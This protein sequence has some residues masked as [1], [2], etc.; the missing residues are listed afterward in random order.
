MMCVGS[1]KT[2]LLY[3]ILNIQTLILANMFIMSIRILFAITHISSYY[4]SLYQV[5]IYD[6][7]MDEKL[8]YKIVDYFILHSKQ[9]NIQDAVKDNDKLDNVIIDA[10]TVS[11]TLIQYYNTIYTSQSLQLQASDIENEK[12][13]K[14]S[15]TLS[16]KSV[17]LEK[18]SSLMTNMQA[19]LLGL[20]NK[21][22]L[23]VLF[24]V[25]MLSHFLSTFMLYAKEFQYFIINT[26][27]INT[28]STYSI[29]Q[30]MQQFGIDETVQFLQQFSQKN[31]NIYGLIDKVSNI[32]NTTHSPNNYNIFEQIISNNYTIPTLQKHLLFLCIIGVN[33]VLVV[34]TIYF[35]DRKRFK[36]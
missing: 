9:D 8:Y 4:D 11:N 5:C 28:P 22:I 16:K 7:Q 12:K 32:T 19:L 1:I 36:I 26:L 34:A 27:Y 2:P 13:V 14:K 10:Q 31:D 3:S 21:I 17:L 15:E 18:T 23:F 24:F 35:L 30:A 33:F 25:F 6:C 20:P 29:R